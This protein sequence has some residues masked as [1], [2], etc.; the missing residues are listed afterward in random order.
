MNNKT[1]IAILFIIILI[2]LIVIPFNEKLKNNYITINRNNISI[3]S[4]LTHKIKKEDIKVEKINISITGNHLQV[5][6]TIKNTSKEDIKGFYINIELL[7]EDKKALTMIT[8][9]S[10]EMIYAGKT[11]ELLNNI[12]EFEDSSII[13]DARIAEFEKNINK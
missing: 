6:T 5:K 1:K 10:K 8:V 4:T 13:K 7:D 9:D 11:I 3:K 2:I 12:E